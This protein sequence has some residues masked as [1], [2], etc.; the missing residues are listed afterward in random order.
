MICADTCIVVY[1]QTEA[2]DALMERRGFP[3]PLDPYGGNLIGAGHR[4]TLVGQEAV[5]DKVPNPFP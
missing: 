4:H 1:V 5:V 2:Y 3:I